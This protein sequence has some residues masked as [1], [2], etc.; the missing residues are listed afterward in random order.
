MSHAVA[1]RTTGFSVPL[2]SDSGTARGAN[3]DL[4]QRPPREVSTTT[5]SPGCQI[6]IS[7]GVE[8]IDL[9]HGSKCHTNN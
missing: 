1:R 4:P 6:V 9:R 2:I 7:G 3:D 5:W 8:V